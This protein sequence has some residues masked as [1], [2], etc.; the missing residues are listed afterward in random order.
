MN[1]MRYKGHSSEQDGEKD[2]EGTLVSSSED[3]CSGDVTGLGD[4]PRGD[5]GQA[6]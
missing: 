3:M 4:D 2:T 5:M 6:A 1:V